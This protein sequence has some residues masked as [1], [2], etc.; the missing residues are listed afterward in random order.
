MCKKWFTAFLIALW[1]ALA[2]APEALAQEVSSQQT[3]EKQD[4]EKSSSE[5]KAVALL[6]QV[7]NE[8]ASLKL[9]E[10]RIRIQIAVADLL[11]EHNE[12]RARSLFD[13]ALAGIVDLMGRQ[14]STS[15]NNRQ[16]PNNRQNF[17]NFNQSRSS[18]TQLRQE[19]VL[20][21]ARHN[22]TLAY[23]Y[24]QATQPQT[25]PADPQNG[26]PFNQEA[27]LE[28]RLLAQIARTDPQLAMKSAEEMLDKGQYSNSFAQVLAQLQTK[29]K[30]AAAKFS[31]KL[32]KRLQTENFLAK[33][34]ASSLAISLVR[35]GP[36]PAD[37]ASSG[38]QTAAANAAQV[39]NETAFNSLMESLITAALK[40]NPPTPGTGRGPNG[41]GGP[42][43]GR[44][45]G[46][47]GNPQQQPQ[48]AAQTEQNTARMLLMGLQSLLPQIDKY[49]PTR[50]SAVHQ[51]LSQFG[52]DNNRAAFNQ[53]TDLVQQGT[54]ESLMTAATSAPADVQPM[55][56]QRAASKALDE[57][58]PDRAK[59]IA[60][61]H[62]SPAQRGNILQMVEAQQLALKSSDD[63]MESIR[64]ALGRLS[65]DEDRIRLLLQL[66]RTNE[67][68]NPK[69]ALQ[70]LTEAQKLVS[71][72]VT[73]YQ[74]FDNQLQVAKAFATVD[75][76]RS[77]EILDP[78]ITQLNELLPAAAL[79][80]GF[81]LNIFR[82][83]ELPLQ[84]GSRLSGTVNQYAE[85]LAQLAKNDF[86][87]AQ[88]TA[89]KFQLLEA[90]IFT[91]LAI[92]RGVLG[93]QASTN[94]NF[95]NRGFGPN[96][97]FARRPQ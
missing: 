7:V 24:L 65:S 63:A 72:R 49:L 36:K 19:L 25:Q 29:D 2:A 15:N 54:S 60:T 68:S 38:A 61:E 40:A 76:A 83:G 31:E 23:Q 93:G 16:N 89:E 67:K 46:F 20:S 27:G 53:I 97:P 57:G 50:A 10:N 58:N 92:A 70:I 14:S 21:A 95:G 11:W 39:L 45:N 47:G 4:K 86:E 55:L 32:L 43:G 26:R 51:K 30:D 35:P 90:R 12:E 66:A 41:F 91:R 48:D 18:A 81:E 52:M 69:L 87:R 28:Q 75:A 84:D 88:L 79:L 44:P 80:S 6:D 56:Y 1:L 17:M 85:E 34:D 3:S 82:D 13:L 33:P 77:F 96:A 9:P 5:D 37:S 74:Q 71:G 78:G 22:A 42:N 73:S 94:T 59:Q 64:Q 8:S 62:L